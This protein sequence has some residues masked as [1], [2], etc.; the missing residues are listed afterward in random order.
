MELV[1]ILYELAIHAVREAKVC[2]RSMDPAGR[3]RA[4]SDAVEVLAE[5]IHSLNLSEGAGL[6][7]RLRDLYGY[8]QQRLLEAH[9][10]KNETLLVEVEGL[11]TTLLEAWRGLNAQPAAD[12]QTGPP[13]D[14]P[15]PRGHYGAFSAAAPASTQDW[16]L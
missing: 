1:C 2:H 16:R 10:T 11:L 8:M 3:G 6:S 15:V 14:P 5:L 7:L 12:G 13:A 4:V 9:T